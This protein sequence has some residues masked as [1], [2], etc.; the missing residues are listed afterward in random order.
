[1]KDYQC[2]ICG[3]LMRCIGIDTMYFHLKC[4]C[5]NETLIQ[6]EEHNEPVKP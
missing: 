1:M 6:K 4:S 5:G 3:L 2:P